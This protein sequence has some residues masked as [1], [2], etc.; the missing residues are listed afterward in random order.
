[1]IYAWRFVRRLPGL[2][3]RLTKAAVRHLVI[4]P[5]RWLVNRG[6]MRLHAFLLWRKGQ[7]DEVQ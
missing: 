6:K 7:V 5:I 4:G 2:A 1:M 3:L